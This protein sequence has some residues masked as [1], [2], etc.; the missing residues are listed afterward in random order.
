M[1][2]AVIS[3]ACDYYKERQILSLKDEINSQEVTVF[4]GAFGNS[5]S[6]PIREIV[7]GDVVSIHA[8]DRVPADCVLLEEM[9]ITIDESLYFNSKDGGS[10]KHAKEASKYY[11]PDHVDDLGISVPDNHKSH[12]DPFI[13]S[14]SK[15]MSG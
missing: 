6:I 3:A 12:P 11:G 10:K 9:N 13:F 7:V 8:G 1:F 4:R 2:A 15:V 5:V 14:D